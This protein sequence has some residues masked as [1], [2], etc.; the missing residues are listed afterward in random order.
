MIYA[1]S[2]VIQEK[3]VDQYCFK[4]CGKIIIGGID[5]KEWGPFCP[6]KTESC[7]FEEDRTSVMG[8][9]F[10]EDV[11]VRKL[12]PTDTLSEP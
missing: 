12:K 10:N 2:P 5:M 4:E 3:E 9:V 11:C 8:Q 7:P 6:C 1:V